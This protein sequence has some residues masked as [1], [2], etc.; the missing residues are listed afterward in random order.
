VADFVKAGADWVSVHVEASPHLHRTLQQI[1][2]LGA[3]AGVVLNP[4]TS[5]ESIRHV[6]PDA[7][8]VL[9]MS[10]NPGFGG[11]SFISSAYQK[12]RDIKILVASRAVEV[13][14]DGGVKRDNA[15]ALARAGASV[16]VA[17]SAVFGTP[18]PAQAVRELRSASEVAK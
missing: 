1:R 6:L 18:D 11:Q 5:E 16:L 2:H 14:V 13:S 3:K 4:H 12:I 10:V 9:V 7:D 15:G 8:L 17:G